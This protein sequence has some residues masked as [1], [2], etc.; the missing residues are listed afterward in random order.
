MR[1]STWLSLALLFSLVVAI[2]AACGGDD[3]AGDTAA[4]EGERQTVKF[5][6]FPA[7]PAGLPLLVM[8]E[9]GIDEKHG[10]NAEYLEVDPDAATNTF[11]IGESDIA[12]EQDAVNMIIARGEGHR[13]VI[14]GPGLEM[15]TGVVVPEDSSARTPADLKGKK[16]GHFGVDSGTTSTIALMLKELHGI[17]VF[18]DYELREAGPEALPELLKSGEVE[19]IFDYE[20]LALRAVLETPGRYVFQPAKA[21]AERTGGW[22][23][24]LTNLAGREEWLRENRE[25][26]LNIEKAW[27][28]ATQVLIDSKYEMLRN[29]P[30]KKH[31][32]LKSDEEL[33]A[34]IEYC[35]DLPCFRNEWTQEDLDSLNEYLQVMADSDILIKDV[36]DE[37]VAV[38]LEDFLNE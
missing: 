18:K 17:D 14:F 34:F 21:W 7:D 32:A 24:W 23:P 5:Q 1:R 33:N 9:E 37:P 25:L 13:A 28:E 12:M 4:A 11:L 16:V 38:I 27:K 15:M 10:F 19:A 26:A 36:P 2:A 6:G 8:Q 30:Y 20:P 35:V 3:E 31:L 29:D 22:G